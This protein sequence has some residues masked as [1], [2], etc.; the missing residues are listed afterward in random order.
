FFHP[1]SYYLISF[2]FLGTVC[3][4]HSRKR[5]LQQESA[6]GNLSGSGC[7][8]TFFAQMRISGGEPQD[9]AKQHNLSDR[10]KDSSA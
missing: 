7:N 8:M 10:K 6:L 9:R 1:L 2:P 3:I 4:Q 5:G